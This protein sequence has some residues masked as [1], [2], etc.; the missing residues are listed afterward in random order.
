MLTHHASDVKARRPGLWIAGTARMPHVADFDWS[1]DYGRLL[2]E[3]SAMFA[4]E[5]LIPR[6]DADGTPTRPFLLQWRSAPIE[7]WKAALSPLDEPFWLF[8]KPGNL[9]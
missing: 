6:F 4:A 5:V 1:A 7:V 2:L 8:E 9:L 3:S